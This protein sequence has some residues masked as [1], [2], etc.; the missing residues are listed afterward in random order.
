MTSEIGFV[1]TDSLM[2]TTNIAVLITCYNRKQK[3]LTCLNGLFQQVLPPETAFLVYL[4]DDGS[5]DGTAKAI[6]QTYPQVQVIQGSGNLFWNQ[7][8]RQAFGAAIQHNHDYHL[9]LNDDTVLYPDAL[10]T[11]LAA[12]QKLIKQG[13]QWAIIVGSAQDPE[14]G[15]LTYGGVVRT[16]RWHPLKYRKVA[17]TGAL[18]LCDMMNGN[19]V[20]VPKSVFER[21]GNLD[22]A[23]SHSIGDFDYALRAKQ[24]GCSVWVAPV[25]VGTCRRNPPQST[26]WNHPDLTLRE[27]FKRVNQPKGLPFKEQ[28]VFMQ[29][30][31]GSFWFVYWS[32]PYIRLFL[33]SVFRRGSLQLKSPTTGTSQS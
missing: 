12:S 26:V 28:K 6:Q 33:S 4:V 29:R 16:S 21:L 23:F 8:M 17:P 15:E 24:Q 11:L 25:Y 3:T 5:T 1:V 30:H 18:Q 22:A 19:C 13:N 7:G 31:G 32:M 2:P 20:L 10:A 14:S 9:W 27:R